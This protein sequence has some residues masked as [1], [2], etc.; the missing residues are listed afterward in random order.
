MFFCTV[1]LY[2]FAFLVDFG[3]NKSNK[4]DC[5]SS[6]IQIQTKQT[7]E[8]KHGRIKSMFTIIV[9]VMSLF[10]LFQL[11]TIVGVVVVAVYALKLLIELVKYW[12]SR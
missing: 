3:I 4:R 1:F 11:G 7:H 6:T 12:R 9:F 5:S 8:D 10:F 2:F